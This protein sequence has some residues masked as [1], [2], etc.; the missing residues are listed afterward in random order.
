MASNDHL[1]DLIQSMPDIHELLRTSFEFDIER[2]GCGAGLRLATGA[3]LEPIAGDFTGGASSCAL[4]K[5]AAAQWCSRAP[6]G[7]AG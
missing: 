3:P 5:A 6:R 1:L 4:R 2:K 7:L